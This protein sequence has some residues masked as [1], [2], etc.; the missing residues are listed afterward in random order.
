MEQKNSP[1]RDLEKK[2]FS[3]AR[4]ELDKVDPLHRGKKFFQTN[5]YH[6]ESRG[7]SLLNR[8]ILLKKILLVLQDPR[9][10][11]RHTVHTPVSETMFVANSYGEPSIIGTYNLLKNIKNHS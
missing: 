1:M 9:C 6:L 4:N 8:L 10:P 5:D 7:L 2:H 11:G 3:I